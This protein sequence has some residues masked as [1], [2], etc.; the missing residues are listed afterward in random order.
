VWEWVNDFYSGTYYQSSPAKN[1]IGPTSGTNRVMRGGGSW[2][3]SEY[4]VR[5]AFRDNYEPDNI[6]DMFDSGFRCA[7]S[8]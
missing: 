4:F 1:P 5:S 3:I 8:Q 6:I 2:V 7:R